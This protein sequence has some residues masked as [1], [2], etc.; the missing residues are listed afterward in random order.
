[1]IGS[2]KVT[3]IFVSTNTGRCGGYPPLA[4]PLGAS[5]GHGSV[6]SIGVDLAPRAVA[7]I[8]LMT[9]VATC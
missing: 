8:V 2:A 5:S 1:M 3:S 7:R 9:G 6:T 4:T